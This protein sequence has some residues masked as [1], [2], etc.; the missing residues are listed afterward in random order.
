MRKTELLRKEEDLKIELAK[1]EDQLLEV[2]RRL[3][4]RNSSGNLVFA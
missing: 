4:T 2:S 1:L 3:S